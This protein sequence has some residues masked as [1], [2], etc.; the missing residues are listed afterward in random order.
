MVSTSPYV[1]QGVEITNSRD[2]ISPSVA[3][4]HIYSESKDGENIYAVNTPQ[5][6]DNVYLSTKDADQA[7]ILN[8]VEE[9]LKHQSDNPN[10]SLADANKG[11]NVVPRFVYNGKDLGYLQ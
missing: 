1:G 7:E 3:S 5:Q 4:V 9:E 2:G 8:R 6:P 11:A 10:F